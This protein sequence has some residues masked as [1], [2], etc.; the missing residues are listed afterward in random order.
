MTMGSATRVFLA[1]LR[2]I[3]VFDPNGDQVGKVRDAVAILRLE[4]NPPILTGLVVEVPPRRRIFIPMGIVLAI[5]LCVALRQWRDALIALGT[6]G[7][8]LMIVYGIVTLTSGRWHFLN[9]M[10][11]PLLLGASLDYMLH[12]IFALRREGGDVRRV[13]RSTGMAV[14][15]CSLSTAVGFCS[16]LLASNDAL[17]DLGIVTGLGILVSAGLALLLLP[18]LWLRCSA[19]EG[20]PLRTPPDGDALD[21]QA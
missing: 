5:T 10:G 19:K 3:G 11:L 1:H 7:L 4:P 18:G 15:F 14:L 2:G 17:V 6:L 16:L 9:L 20:A 21:Q 8:S 13:L 12:I